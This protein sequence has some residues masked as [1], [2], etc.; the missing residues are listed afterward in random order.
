MTEQPPEESPQVGQGAVT[1]SAPEPSGEPVPAEA[2]EPEPEPEPEPTPE[3]L[4]AQ[5]E[6]QHT[7]F[8]STYEPVLTRLPDALGTS[9]EQEYE[10]AGVDAEGEPEHE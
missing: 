3:E 1:G 9:P 10:P 5:E 6:A 2:P 7:H 8:L 4:A